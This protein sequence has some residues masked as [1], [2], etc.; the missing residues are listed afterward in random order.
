MKFSIA[1][2]LAVAWFTLSSL[3][4]HAEKPDAKK[5]IAADIW[6]RDQF[7]EA[8]D[9]FMRCIDGQLSVEYGQMFAFANIMPMIHREYAVGWLDR[10]FFPWS[11]SFAHDEY[12]SVDFL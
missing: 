11:D 10:M 9:R 6:W 4:V 1:A 3:V 7:S 5:E 2:L 12:T 8:E